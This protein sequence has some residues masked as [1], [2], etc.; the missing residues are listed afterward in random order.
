MGITFD[1]LGTKPDKDFYS[2]GTVGT[3]LDRVGRLFDT[4][5]SIILDSLPAHKNKIN[6][7]FVETLI[8]FDKNP[9]YLVKLMFNE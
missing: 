5:G 4:M 8:P 9:L 6:L 1:T 2:F 7:H 3:E